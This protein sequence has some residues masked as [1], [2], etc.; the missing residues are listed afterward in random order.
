MWEEKY[1]YVGNNRKVIMKRNLK[2]EYF[3]KV[4]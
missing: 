3:L 1:M 4:T 2:Y